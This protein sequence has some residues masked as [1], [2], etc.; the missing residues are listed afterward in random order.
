MHIGAQIPIPALTAFAVL[1]QGIWTPLI[2]S[3]CSSWPLCS[4]M[5]DV[6]RR[7][8]L[9]T[10][11]CGNPGTVGWARY[12][13]GKTKIHHPLGNGPEWFIPPIY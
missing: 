3:A 9:T 11:R 13:V 1:V 4:T 5:P 7:R 2:R 10:I 8:R 6:T 12:N